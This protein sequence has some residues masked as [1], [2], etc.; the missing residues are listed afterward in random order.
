MSKPSTTV[1]KCNDFNQIVTLDLKMWGTKYI[2]WMVCSFTRFIKGVVI[3]DKEGKTIM[4]AVVNQWNCNFGVPS[5]GYW[6]DNG[7]EFRNADMSEFC[8]KNGLSIKFGP[9]YSPWANGINERNHA[10]ADKTIAKILEQDGKIK[11]SEAVSLAGWCHNT[12]VN[13]LGYSPLQ[14]VTGKAV[15]FPGITTGNIASDSSFDSESVKKIMMRHMAMMKEF[16]V[17]EYTDKLESVLKYNSKSWQNIRY[18]QGDE[19]F[20]QLKDKKAWSGPV[21]VFAQDGADIWVFHNGNLVKLA[22]CRVMP[23]VGQ[24]EQERRDNTGWTK[25]NWD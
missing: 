25:K 15:I 13:R 16:Q 3:A 4:E 10:S 22:T 1:P 2:L 12:N 7:G 21:K 5:I 23:V 9:A 18:K 24:H 8:D 6:C 14:L 17:A 19:L 11:L 20:I